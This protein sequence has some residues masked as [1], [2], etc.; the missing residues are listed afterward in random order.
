MK[1]RTMYPEQPP[2]QHVQFEPYEAIVKA[3]GGKPIAYGCPVCQLQFEAKP[4]PTAC[5]L[6]GSQY[7]IMVDRK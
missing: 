2:E 6:C 1:G 5:P 7:V 4:G 3:Q